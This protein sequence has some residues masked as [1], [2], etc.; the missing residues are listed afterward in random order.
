MRV[1]KATVFRILWVTVLVLWCAYIFSN[2]LTSAVRS[3]EK[4]QDVLASVDGFIKQHN[5]NLEISHHLI[6]KA[7]HFIEFFVLGALL[8]LFP[9]VWNLSGKGYPFYTSFVGLVIAL[10]DE[11]LQLFVKGR[12]SSVA[13]VWL[14]FSAVIVAHLLY[15][16]F[17][18]LIKRLKHKKSL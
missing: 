1:N 7:A 14:D 13:D 12:E 18:L 2:S 8:S 11:T 4:S 16:L 10:T 9:T 3:S 5:G 17:V 15:F 6:R